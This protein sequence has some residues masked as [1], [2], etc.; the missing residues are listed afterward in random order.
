MPHYFS[1]LHFNF[2]QQSVVRHELKKYCTRNAIVLKKKKK[3]AKFAFTTRR[4]ITRF[5]TKNLS[6]NLFLT[7]STIRVRKKLE[8]S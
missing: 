7:I 6:F 3:T 2:I 5:F 1:T 4:L 8:K